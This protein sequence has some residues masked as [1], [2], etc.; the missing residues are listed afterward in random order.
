MERKQ[1]T[2][3]P[4]FKCQEKINELY[5]TTW[6]IISSPTACHL[7]RAMAEQERPAAEALEYLS[8]FLRLNN[9]VRKQNPGEYKNFHKVVGSWCRQVMENLYYEL[10]QKKQRTSDWS[11]FKKGAVYLKPD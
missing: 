2:E 4:L 5:P 11:V 3:H 8:S 6:D 1:D 10:K 7:M 9:L